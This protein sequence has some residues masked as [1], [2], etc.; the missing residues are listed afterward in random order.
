MK[1]KRSTEKVK[2]PPSQTDTNTLPPAG[3]TAGTAGFDPL[4][5][6]RADDQRDCRFGGTNKEEKKADFRYL[7]KL[8]DVVGEQVNNLARGGLSHGGAAEAQSLQTNMSLHHGSRRS[9]FQTLDRSVKICL[10]IFPAPL[11]HLHVYHVA[12]GNSDLHAGPLHIVE[13]EV[14]KKRQA[15]GADRQTGGIA[16]SDVKGLLISRVIVLKVQ[17]QLAQENWLHHFNDLL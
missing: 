5:P 6:K 8:V 15:D 12:H 16:E 17:N 7:V 3:R 2:A 14:M 4:E 9:W 10:H 11:T 1:P 13:V